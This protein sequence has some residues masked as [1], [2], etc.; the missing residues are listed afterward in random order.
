ML[1]EKYIYGSGSDSSLDSGEGWFAF[2]GCEFFRIAKQNAFLLGFFL[3]CRFREFKFGNL[4][5]YILILENI[6]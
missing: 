6:F 4:K 1:R 2:D 5:K 3:V